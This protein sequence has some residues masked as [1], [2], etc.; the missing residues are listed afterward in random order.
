MDRARAKAAGLVF[1][2]S[3]DLRFPS[4][5]TAVLQFSRAFSKMIWNSSVPERTG[6]GTVIFGIFRR[7]QIATTVMS[8]IVISAVLPFI[9][10]GSS[11]AA[12]AVA[13]NKVTAI[14]ID[15]LGKA[16]GVE[17]PESKYRQSLQAG[18]TAVSA[19]FQN[20]LNKT[21]NTNN[22]PTAWRMQSI[23]VGIGLSGEFG[24]GPLINISLSPSMRLIFTNHQKRAS[25]N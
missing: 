6:G 10:G 8:A 5:T 1:G 18:M 2:F 7:R 19:S 13:E 11:C 21:K 20:T 22:P 17:I 3:Q 9:S 4:E 23:G 15:A 24:L 12:A 16:V 25:L 14:G